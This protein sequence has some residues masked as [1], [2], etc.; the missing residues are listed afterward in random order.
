MLSILIDSWSLVAT[1]WF[2][3]TIILKLF[4]RVGYSN[5]KGCY[6]IRIV[7]GIEYCI[8]TSRDGA[9][10]FKEEPNKLEIY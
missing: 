5:I 7:I 10:I 1:F 8:N 6:C 2:V 3:F 4:D 9:K